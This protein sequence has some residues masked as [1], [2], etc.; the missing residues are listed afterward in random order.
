MAQKKSRKRLKTS[1][2]GDAASAYR[3]ER[4][5]RGMNIMRQMGREDTLLEQKAL[6]EDLYD[7]SVGHLFGDIWSRPGLGLRERQFITLAANI[8]MARATGNHSHYRSAL[9]LGITKEEIIETIIHV[10]HYTGWPTLHNAVVQFSE[11][12]AELESKPSATR[13][14]SAQRKS[15]Q[16]TRQ[17]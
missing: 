13:T 16:R 2:T 15:T 7:I 4:F 17:P 8:A 11:V 14:K 12:L 1:A 10:G 3:A 6:S 5:E 9:H